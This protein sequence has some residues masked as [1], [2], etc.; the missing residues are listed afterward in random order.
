M[1]QRDQDR[2][3]STRP[4]R[5]EG[6]QARAAKHADHLIACHLQPDWPGWHTCPLLLSARR[7]TVPPLPC[8]LA[9]FR[10][11]QEHPKGEAGK[12]NALSASEL[13]GSERRCA[14]WG[15][16][17]WGPCWEHDTQ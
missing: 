5:S 9:S 14:Q 10:T 13:R 3:Q 6:A 2:G 4:Q 7:L 15:V 12:E 8:R 11:I 1:E 16:W 17:L